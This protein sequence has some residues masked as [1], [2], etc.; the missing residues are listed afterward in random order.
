VIKTITGRDRP[1][2]GN[3]RGDWF[4]GGASFPSEHAAA[5]WSIATVV[6]GQYPGWMTKLLA[7]GGAA[8]VSAARV[9]GREHFAS[10]ALIGSA[11]GWY[12][13]HHVLN[14]EETASC[15]LFRTCSERSRRVASYGT[16]EKGQ[17]QAER[18]PDYPITRSP[19][20]VDHPISGSPD[21]IHS[22]VS[23]LPNYQI[24][25]LPNY[26]TEKE[27]RT[28]KN[29]GSPYVP[30]DSWVYPAFDRLIALGY[31][32]S[33][34]FSLRPWTRLE[35]ARL[36]Q[37]VESV[38]GDDSSMGFAGRELRAESRE[39]RREFAP[40]LALI[41]GGGR[42]LS[43]QIESVYTRFTDISG[44]PLTDGYHF[45]QTLFDDYGRPYQEGLNNVTGVSAYTTVGPLALY[46]KGEY[47]Y[48]P[49][50]PALSPS[51]Q[52]AIAAADRLPITDV[53]G[54]PFAATN[55]FRLLDSYVALNVSNW[56]LSFGKQS[57]WFGPNEGSSLQYSDNAEPVWMLR[58]SRVSPFKLPSI[59]G[60]LGP[61]RN[62]SFLGQLQG[63]DLIRLAYPDWQLV[64]T[65]GVPVN[66]Q[67]YIWGQKINFHPTPNFEFGV[68]A[69]GIFAGYGRP[70]TLDTFLHTFSLNGNAQAVDP[71]K[72]T[73][74]F[75]FSYRI[76][77]LRNWLTLYASSI[78]WD[79]INPIA[80]PRRSA[81]NPGIY[82]PKL[83][84]LPNLDL[85]VEG[86]YT[87][88]PNLKGTGVFYDNTH[89]A[90]GYTNYGQ[91]MGSWVGRQ[92]RGIQA[93]ST[94][95]LS[96]QRTLQAYYRY[97]R[98]DPDFAGGGHIYDLGAQ[99][100]YAVR[101]FTIAPTV[102][103]E[104][105]NFPALMSTRQF[106]V[107]TSVQLTYRPNWRHPAGSQ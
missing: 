71:G 94:Y 102:Q 8:A 40:E 62:E 42:N 18:S 61:I 54:G 64:G 2:E 35:C 16:F 5:A 46:M 30:L 77:G 59:F 87:D 70:L 31:I 72:R 75:D 1:L 98:V 17:Q 107:T 73:G 6:A 96:P 66:P 103:F 92:G 12:I 28:V 14:R 83:P 74:G 60:W 90:D 81:M 56:Q 57:L 37:E 9:T 78:T 21:G 82:L 11:L 80:Y 95:W 3:G 38:M 68:S 39:L 93:W 89:Y 32:Q 48:A 51:T 27:P 106:N 105:W 34:F 99:A 100:N 29:M 47:Q 69:V 44:R 65:L 91:I 24:T 58:L 41:E 22:S 33:G 26:S 52:A 45:G 86:I 10:D 85:R 101:Q 97:E 36:L 4:Q 15:P 49:S 76:P 84:H 19:D 67:P 50:G 79:E 20:G 88:L 7:Y 43:A 25:K 104:R 23:Q 63:H 55:R 53:A 13:G